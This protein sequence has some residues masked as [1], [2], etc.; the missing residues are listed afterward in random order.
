MYELD[1]KEL[2]AIK[3]V[4][5]RR[6]LFRFQGP[7]VKTECSLFE[8][9]FADAM[10]S[11]HSLILTSGTNALVASLRALGIGPGDEVLVPAFTFIATVAAVVEVGAIPIIVNIDQHLGL[12]PK[13]CAEKMSPFTRAMIPVH[14]D[15]L[16]CNMPALLTLAQEK[17][18]HV[19]EDVAQA[20]GGHHGKKALGT[21]GVFGCYS[22][23]EDKI[24]SCGE[25]GAL[26]TNSFE[27]Y[28]RALVA[29]DSPSPFG[30]S[31]KDLFPEGV[32]FIGSSM[33]V[34]EISG[35]MMRVQLQRLKSIVERL[36]AK[37]EK[38]VDDLERAGPT[39]VKA[40]DPSGDCGTSL[41]ILCSDPIHAMSFGKKLMQAGIPAIP[42]SI[43]PAHAAWQWLSLLKEERFVH[44]E[45]NPLK[46][47][48]REISYERG[49]L[50]P[51]IEVLM[52][53]IKIPLTLESAHDSKTIISH[54]R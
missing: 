37:K 22:F 28:K 53:L 12:C 31:N 11:T 18:L 32:P 21:H 36:H 17:N 15:G 2:Q 19:V 10:K 43:R 35:A 51:S 24:I 49:P 3:A 7:G 5:E 39:I 33:R 42:T 46:H 47:K 50:M 25:G 8:S 30:A 14:M 23:N 45:R 1:D 38:L 26:V 54:Y 13:D 16:N 41:H 20:V 52:R 48:Q 6:R 9:E 27:L 29:H 4:L 40:H 34:S 44:P